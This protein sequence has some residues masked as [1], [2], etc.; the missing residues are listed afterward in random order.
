MKIILRGLDS[1][2]APGPRNLRTG[3]VG[4]DTDGFILCPSSFNSVV[5]IRPTLGLTSRTGVMPITPLQDTVGQ[6]D[7]PGGV[8]HGAC[9]G[10][11]WRLRRAGRRGHRSSV[12]VHPSRRVQAVPEVGRAERQEDRCPPW[13]LPIICRHATNVGVRAAPH[14]HEETWGVMVD[15][16]RVGPIR[17]LCGMIPAPTRDR[18]AGRVKSSA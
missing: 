8:G 12:Q 16:L 10:R 13:I 1:S 5:G 4:T 2:L 11:H 18:S 9:A 3:H 14:H 6:A 17:R 7:L 15:N